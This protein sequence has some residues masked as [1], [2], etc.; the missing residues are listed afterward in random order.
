[1]ATIEK[2]RAGDGICTYRARVRL[3]GHPSATATFVRLTDAKRWAQST[4]ASIR[5]GRYFKTAE[6]KR[7]T[8][9]ELIDRYEREVLA[10]EPKNAKNTRRNLRWWGA[11]IGPLTLADVTPAVI[12]ECRSALLATSTRRKRPM[13]PATVA[14]YMAALSHALT[15]AVREWQWLDDSP[16]R[17]VSKPREP[18]GR[19][20]FLSEDERQRLLNACKV[21]SQQWL[22]A[23]VVLAIS[24]GMRRGE[25]LTLRWPQ[26]DLKAGRILL[27]QTKNGS[28]RAV[29]LSGVA[30][31]LIADLAKVRRIDSDLLF[32]GDDV[33]KPFALDNHWRRALEVAKVHDFKFHDLRHTA[34]SYL[35]MNGASTIEI[36]AVLGH[37]T[38]A[39]VQRYSHLSSSHT[40]AVVASMNERIF[41]RIANE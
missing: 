33:S 25:I 2:R 31:A 12:V 37:K 9:A 6:A 4:E 35:A 10:C 22:Y 16:M 26:V 20:R 41:G 38:L 8:V 13:S 7:H 28:S 3:K 29:P 18:R 34:A 17:K 5:D 15:I 19:E 11:R 23:V 40:E 1:M 39:M 21:S 14:R 36:A 32:F 27:H 30:L 24:T